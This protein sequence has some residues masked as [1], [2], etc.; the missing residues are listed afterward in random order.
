[1]MGRLYSASI[2]NEAQTTAKTLVEIAAAAD[3][4]VTLERMWISQSDFDTSENLGVKVEDETTTGTGTTFTAPLPFPLVTSDT[5]STAVVKTNFTIEPTYSGG[6]Y[7]TQGFNVLSG[8]LWT[9]AND[10]EVIVISPSQLAGIRL[11][12]APSGSMNFSYGLIYRE[13]GG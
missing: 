7:L 1:M 3:L 12:V 5:P 2:P 11:D 10:D 4:I 9:P 6:I 8:W 13:I